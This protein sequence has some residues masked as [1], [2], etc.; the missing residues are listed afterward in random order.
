M[1]YNLYG[2]TDIMVR[3]RH[4]DYYDI[5]AQLLEESRRHGRQSAGGHSTLFFSWYSLLHL[6][7][8]AYGYLL[9][10][11]ILLLFML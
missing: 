1:T 6:Q 5:V 11:K 7:Y 4:A 10:V 2:T 9:V 3:S 8:F